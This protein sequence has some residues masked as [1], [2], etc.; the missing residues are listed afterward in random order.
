MTLDYLCYFLIPIS[1]HRYRTSGHRTKLIH[2]ISQAA[3]SKMG[4][5]QSGDG[6]V[7]LYLMQDS[8]NPNRATTTSRC[9]TSQNRNKLLESFVA[10]VVLVVL[11]TAMH[12]A[13]LWPYCLN[14]QSLRWCREALNATAQDKGIREA[15]RGWFCT[16]PMVD[17]QKCIRDAV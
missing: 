1:G 2:N 11:F 9:M 5:T 16:A 6:A 4:T 8:W 12:K 15:L 13:P 17:Y 10:L 14:S 7:F 3:I